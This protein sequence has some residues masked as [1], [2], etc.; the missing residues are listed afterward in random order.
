[1]NEDK[2]HET[3]NVVSGTTIKAP[4]I[5]VKESTQAHYYDFEY[6]SYDNNA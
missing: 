5:P 6:W 1:M 2:I 3:R 4:V